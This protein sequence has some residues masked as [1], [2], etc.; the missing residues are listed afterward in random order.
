MS[1]GHGAC[2]PGNDGRCIT[3][4]YYLNKN[5]N[6]TVEILRRRHQ[7]LFDRL[8][9]FWSDRKEPSRVVFSFPGTP[10][11]VW[12]FNSEERAEAKRRFRKQT[13]ES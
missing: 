7:P 5:W 10:I 9:L 12:Y 8:L 13:G 1:S 3:C 2:Y 4:I 11:T 6:H